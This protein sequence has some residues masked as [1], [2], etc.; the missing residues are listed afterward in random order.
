MHHKESVAKS[1]RYGSYG[2]HSLRH[3]FTSQSL[4]L[5]LVLCTHNNSLK[6]RDLDFD[7]I[8]NSVINKKIECIHG[9]S[10]NVLI[11]FGASICFFR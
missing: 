11:P 2:I 9:K 8:V 6:K 7:Q 3:L 5:L 4:K 1:G 10:H